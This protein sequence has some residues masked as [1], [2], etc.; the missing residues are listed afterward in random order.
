MEHVGASWIKI[1]DFVGDSNEDN[2]FNFFLIIFE[3]IKRFPEYL[4][5]E[6]EMYYT[7]LQAW[8]KVIK[9]ARKN[10]EIKSHTSD[11]QLAALF[12]LCSDGVFIR[13]IN[14]D[15]KSGFKTNLMQAFDNIYNCLG[16]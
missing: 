11:K 9:N 6:H 12:L 7:D 8:T 1:N 10:S 2:T 13:N 14:N 3:A 4:K 5:M 15:K 16:I